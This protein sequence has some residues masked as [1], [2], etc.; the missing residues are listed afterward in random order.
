MD[1]V[2]LGDEMREYFAG[3]SGVACAFAI[4]SVEDVGHGCSYLNDL[5]L[6]I[7]GRV[8]LAVLQGLA[9]FAHAGFGFGYSIGLNCQAAIA[10]RC[11][12]PESDGICV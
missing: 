8:Y 1:V 4:D 9:T 3:A 7:E 2:S 6:K 11:G 12:Q 10:A 5:C